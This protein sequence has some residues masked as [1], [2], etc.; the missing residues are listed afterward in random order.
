MDKRRIYLILVVFA[1]FIGGLSI[2][3]F[4]Q[5][6]VG[7]F[8]FDQMSYNYISGVMIPPQNSVDGALGGYSTI[9]GKG[10]NFNF[11]IRLP[12]AENS[13]N[14]LDYTADGLKGSGKLDYIH[15][16]F[17]TLKSF[18]Y[19]DM[20][21]A[22]LG[23]KLSGTYNMSCA[24]W[25]GDGNFKNNGNNFTGTF[26]IYGPMT[27][28]EGNFTMELQGKK[29]AIISDHIRHPNRDPNNITKV[30]STVYM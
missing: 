10:R 21:G 11:L 13:E 27:Y 4:T 7:Q 1:L 19:G 6:S 14:P 9:D 2:L 20:K 22:M 5:G 18:L 17:G 24:A 12:G 30:Q 26:K 28:F 23:T 8:V 29:M 25:A 16:T 3:E 15:F